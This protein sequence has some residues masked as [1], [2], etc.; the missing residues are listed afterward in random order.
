MGLPCQNRS[1]IS[2]DLKGKEEACFKG[3]KRKEKRIEGIRYLGLVIGTQRTLHQGKML[4]RSLILVYNQE[5]LGEDMFYFQYEFSRLE[6]I[7]INKSF[8]L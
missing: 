7:V 2:L 8:A 3:E 5:Y 6:Y 1:T 4:M